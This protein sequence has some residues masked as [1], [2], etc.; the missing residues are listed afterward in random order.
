MQKFPL[1]VHLGS[2]LENNTWM[3]LAVRQR[4][5]PSRRGNSIKRGGENVGFLDAV[6][7][8]VFVL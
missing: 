4:Q 8:N 2:M 6:Y 1:D 5:A 3:I 7:Y